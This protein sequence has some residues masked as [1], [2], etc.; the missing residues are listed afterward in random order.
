[1]F[2]MSRNSGQSW[3]IRIG[4]GQ[5]RGRALV[6]EKV[7]YCSI[8]HDAGLRTK[9]YIVEVNGTGVFGM[10]HDDCKNLI[11][12]A[13]DHVVLRVE[14]GDFIVPNMDEAFPKKE[15]QV[16]V[17]EPDGGPEHQKDKPYW[18]KNIEDGQG[19]RNAKGFTTVGKPKMASKQYN[20]PME[21]YGEEALDEIMKEGTLNGKPFDISNLMNP[22]GKEFDQNT[23][24]VLAMIQQNGSAATAAAGGAG[25][26]RSLLQNA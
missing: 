7:N 5:D 6:L 10:G 20:S 18:I 25:P 23:S 13:G 24:S 8:A 14:R 15:G 17:S 3:G 21:M 22:S 9:D 2:D 1:M 11:K 4:G 12:K 19:V 26:P 16:T